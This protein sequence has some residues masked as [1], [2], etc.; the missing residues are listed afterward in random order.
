MAWS[1]PETSL[2]VGTTATQPNLG[3]TS[4]LLRRVTL[5]RKSN[6]TAT[7]YYIGSSSSVTSSTGLKVTAPAFS[8]DLAAG[9]DIWAITASDTVYL[10]ADVQTGE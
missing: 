3:N 5:F 4:S 7:E 9:E 6:S 2:S 8:F 10:A 1:S